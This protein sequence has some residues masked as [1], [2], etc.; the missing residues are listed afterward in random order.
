MYFNVYTIPVIASVF[1][2][3]ILAF[4][5]RKL[6]TTPGA[7]CFSMLLVATAIYSLFYVLEISSTSV[8]TVLIFYKMEYLGVSVIPFF[9]LF[10]AMNYTGKKH[11]MSA[12]LTAV[13]L[14]VPLTTI[15][16]VFTTEFHG[17]FHKGFYMVNDGLFPVLTY[18][19]GIWYWV[20]QSYSIFCIITG[21][22][23]LLSMLLGTAPAFRKQTL[24]VIVGSMIPFLTLLLFLTG[25][26]PWGIDPAPF[27]MTLSSLII[28]VGLTRHKLFDLAP[29][30]RSMLFENIPDGVIVLDKEQRV[31]DLNHSATTYLQMNASDMG[32]HVSELAQPWS[33]LLSKGSDAT[34]KS[35][36]EFR[37]EAEGSVFWLHVI[38]LPLHDKHGNTRG[39]MVILSN[40][41]ERKNTEEKLL[42]KNRLLKD[43]TEHAN[44][45]AAHAEMASSAKSQFLAMMSHEM[46]TP[47]NGVI[48]FSDLLMQTDL[49]GSQMQ[50]MQAVYS[51]AISLL[52]LI[53]DVLDLSKIE[54]G[55]LDLDPEKTDLVELCEQIMD[56]VKYRA[57]EKGL[58]LLLNIS[59]DLPRYIVADRLRLKQV[60]VN[61]LGNAVKFTEHGEVELKVEASPVPG[62]DAAE[63]TFSVRDTGIGIAKE[64]QSR[65]FDSFSQADGSI[66]RKYGGTGLGL[67]ISNML[68]GKMGSGL[69]LES[70][71]G[72]GS[73]FRFTVRFP[74]EAGGTAAHHDLSNVR[75]VLIVD[76]NAAS[77]SILANMLLSAGIRADVAADGA[78]ALDM[79]DA[80]MDYD[81][82]IVDQDMPSMDGPELVRIMRERPG[83]TSGKQAFILLH[84]S[85]ESSSVHKDPGEPG[86]RCL[87]AKP[88]RMSQFFETIAHAY[89]PED[90]L[91]D[92]EC[93]AGPQG[94]V[95]HGRYRIM[96][97]EDNEV[98]MVLAS[99]ILSV[100]LPDAEMIKA[101][102]GNEAVL[103]FKSAQ[104]DL[105]F[106]DIQ[107]PGL[108][109]Y[110]AARAIRKTENGTA[111]R[112]PIIALTAGTVKGERERCLEAGMD[113]YITKPVVAGTIRDVLQRWLPE[114]GCASGSSGTGSKGCVNSG[115]PER[116]KREQLLANID[117]DLEVFNML[118][119][120]AMTTFARG[121]ED[122]KAAYSQKDMQEVRRRAH[123]VRGSAL[124]I[125]CNILAE[126]AAQLEGWK[127]S[128]DAGV[129]ALLQEMG[130]E[131][132]LIG[133]D[134]ETGPLDGIYSQA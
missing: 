131:I 125:G 55:K 34:V 43:A 76:D 11:W 32:R 98:N 35:S 10:F 6:K 56:I 79:V 97:A 112:V 41:T 127:D 81:L 42:E 14:I 46:R 78:A 15:L 80:K 45:M 74:A 75:R 2:L 62:T 69:E 89:C 96:V 48:G 29:L 99:A 129:E 17:L 65:I 114:C 8:N 108:S 105:V 24:F 70:E 60:L 67:T 71:S 92:R 44:S 133:Q 23:L 120:I 126:M 16:L 68:L 26:S 27:S 84:G 50:Y 31:V 94:P 107:M 102:D 91:T 22:S 93:P 95:M 59:A 19:P 20:Q 52:D 83:F 25:M 63:L 103:K 134:I 64:S 86:I 72:K 38:F 28:F 109:G 1:I 117:G 58:E 123:K 51:S 57:H 121:L 54:A 12:S 124:N 37:N 36:I 119:S 90:G 85:S 132:A 77:C 87:L 61:L 113:D 18:E 115:G 101:V 33:D 47:L 4:N 21:M 122:I 53:N 128:D 13:L 110:E 3:C 100:C 39:Q 130:D 5:I 49:T 30:A 118:T 106:M 116:F 82:V 104:P 66:T 9:F 111:G 88:V 40:T 73:T 7:T